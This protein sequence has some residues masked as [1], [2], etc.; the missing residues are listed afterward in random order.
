MF[1]DKPLAGQ[2]ALIT[3]G[4][5]GIGAAISEHLAR[6]GAKIS[7]TARNQETLDARAA[8]LRGDRGAEVFAIAAD[9]SVEADIES[10]FAAAAE[11]LG[12]IDI[13]INNAG[14]GKSAPFH[15]MDLEFWQRTMDL[16]LTGPFLCCKQVY[17]AMR[18]RGY[19]RIINIASTV[20]LRGYPY[21]AAYA[22]SK[23]GVVGLTRSLA[24]EAAKTG[25]TVN[26]VCPGYTDTDLV[27]EAI[28]VIV[29]KTGQDAAHVRA[30]IE[31]TSP[32]GRLIT[33]DEVAET[34]AWLCLPSSAAIT[35]QSIVVAGGS[36][37]N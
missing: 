15:R 21:I 6:M 28:D 27:D 12:P 14:M 13:L 17:A 1:A 30:E 10:G 19:G 31:H 3:G 36:V 32:M 2:H 23:H 8:K 20:G 24:L 33:V 7:L 18:T 5:R 25:I 4:S 22:A 29:D 37:T 11:A 35:G 26:A 34:V 9:M 16:N